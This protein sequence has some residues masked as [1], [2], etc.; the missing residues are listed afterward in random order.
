MKI[1]SVDEI[2]FMDRYAIEKFNVAEEILMENAGMAAVRVLENKVGILDKKF[3]IFCGSGNNG[4]DGLVIA[5]QLH[6]GGGRIKVFL[7]G[8]VN[9]YKGAAKTNFLTITK[10]P[11]EIIKLENVAAAK[12]DIAHCD[13]IVDAIF[14]TGIDRPVTG[15]TEE[16]IL[17]INKSRKR[18]LSLDISSGIN[19]NTGAIM[20][21]AVKADYTVTFGLPKIGNMLYPG[22]E[23]GGE[24]F[25]SHISF[26]PLLTEDNKLKIATNDYVTIP[27]R[28]AEAYKGSMGDVLF[29]A[30]ATNYYG[31]PYF[32]AMSFLKSGGGYARLAAPRCVVPVIAKRGKEIVYLP[33]EETQAGSIALKNKK[34]LLDIAAK[35]D[36]V[37]IG[38]G[39]SLQ[40][41]TGELV[42]EL[43][44]KI[45]VPLL[46]DGDGLTAVA[47]KPGILNNRKAATILTPHMGEIARLTGYSA[48]QINSDKV[49]FLRE[50]AAR[51]KATIVLKGAHSLVGTPDSNVYVNLSGNPG[52]A[53]AGSGDVLTGCIAAMY[54]MRLKS[55]EAVRK[56]VFLHGY[57]GDL[58]AAKKG[59]DGITAKDIMEFL[60]QALKNDRSE[61]IE[62]KYYNPP[63]I[64]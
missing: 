24:L 56:G 55:E 30:G 60:P 4:G 63:V 49:T 50:T 33:Q 6:S 62:V 47:E 44:E 15:L 41:E 23:F 7:L 27:R 36:M 42:R 52:M 40:E 8:D 20:G 53:T 1:A 64:F 13:V 18:V 59:T 38:P 51:L 35:V 31:A 16:V 39:L 5:R 25:V 46:I 12:K 22:Y 14:G 58:A 10:L 43:T 48:A 61:I 19:G 37:V 34:A 26:P 11:V 32:A 29:I 57:A 28:P 17:L 2:R 54:G 45:K 21:A 3:V 9:K